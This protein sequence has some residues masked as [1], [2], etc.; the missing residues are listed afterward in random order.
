MK[1]SK[2]QTDAEAFQVPAL[3]R[4]LTILEL[5]ATHPDG[6]RMREIADRAAQTARDEAKRATTRAE[7]L[8]KALK[9]SP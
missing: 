6:M 5:L 2:N 7:V 8:A 4:A 9:G 1:T 3:A